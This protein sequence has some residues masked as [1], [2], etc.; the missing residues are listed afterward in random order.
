MVL[1][2]DCSAS[3]LVVALQFTVFS[4]LRWRYGESIMR[5]MI[6]EVPNRISYQ[7]YDFS[8]ESLQ[9]DSRVQMTSSNSSSS[10]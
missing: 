8:L 7:L 5:I 10:P 2:N 1:F 4:C 6:F 3:V 9:N